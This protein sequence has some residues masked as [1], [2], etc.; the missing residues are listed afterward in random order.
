MR[1][2]GMNLFRIET[3]T[4]F[5]SCF[6]MRFIKRMDVYVLSYKVLQGNKFLFVRFCFLSDRVGKYY[7]F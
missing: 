1:N 3:R 2:A 7:V 4:L 6:V 5:V